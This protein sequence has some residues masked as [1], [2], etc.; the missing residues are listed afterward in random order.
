MT[1][2]G[3]KWKATDENCGAKKSMIDNAGVAELADL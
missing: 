2:K 3:G 1:L